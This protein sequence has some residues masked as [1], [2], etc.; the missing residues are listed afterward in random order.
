MEPTAPTVDAQTLLDAVP[1]LTVRNGVV[2]AASPGIESELEVTPERVAGQPLTHLGTRL[3][4]SFDALFAGEGTVRLR[5]TAELGDRPIELRLLG[6]DG[7]GSRVSV[8]SLA[9]EF[10][11]QSLLRRSDYG[12][13][14]V[15]PDVE[16]I[17]SMTNNRA[18]SLFPGDDP[19][20]WVEM[21]DPDDMSTMAEAIIEVGEHPDRVRH[22]SHRLNADRA[23]RFSDTVESA[24]HDPDLRGVLIRTRLDDDA[25][26]VVDISTR[27]APATLADDMAVGLM[28]L[29]GEGRLLY[30]NAASTRLLDTTPGEDLFPAGQSDLFST[31]GDADRAALDRAF[32][33]VTIGRAQLVTVASPDTPGTKLRISLTPGAAG[34]VAAVVEDISELI[35]TQEQLE[36]SQDELRYRAT[37][38]DLTD[39]PERT[40]LMEYLDLALAEDIAQG[41][42]TAVIFCDVDNFKLVNDSLGHA[43]GDELLTTMAARMSN[44]VRDADLVG[45]FGGD[46]FVV[47]APGITSSEEAHQLAIRIFHDVTGRV[48]T[49][50][51][52]LDISVSMGV[53]ATELRAANAEALIQHAD[54]AMY[55]AKRNGR[56]RVELYTEGMGA[57]ASYRLQRQTELVDGVHR[58]EFRLDYQPI[59]PT[60]ARLGLAPG[61]EALARWHHPS[62]GI[63]APAAWITLAE[64]AGL[65]DVIGDELIAETCRNI[66][67]VTDRPAFFTVNMSPRQL[68][69]SDAAETVLRLVAAS[70]LSPTSLVIEL[71][72]GA[73]ANDGAVMENL[74]RFRDAGARLFVD[75]FGTGYSS[76]SQLRRFPIDGVKIDRAFIHP[77]PD[78]ELVKVIVDIAQTLGLVTVAE[79]IERQ[80]QLDA[81]TKLGVDYAQG[82]LIG[83]PGP[84]A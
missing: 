26:N 41:L 84:L 38:D 78:I 79:G 6:T 25:P 44:A 18:A 20:D 59:V 8:R 45:R 67:A 72:E 64:D 80:V 4:G 62:E 10:M 58:A 15:S 65:M 14:L 69:R 30:R 74:V 31:L 21:M 50:Q 51:G 28:V 52:A 13:I 73:L 60:G 63:L 27:Y 12:H 1:H 3:D 82:Y 53:A 77:T 40:V 29:T 70:E 76:L 47:V 22:I 48:H 5:L 57:D 56:G 83:A 36:A 37:H 16:V 54:R 23:Y 34:T 55:T 11:L 24:L 7:V 33:M 35:A 71:T 19:M 66:A 46:E 32:E 17:W 81:V 42:L 2:I 68:S 75:D 43:A 9:R 61:V 39:L 49:S